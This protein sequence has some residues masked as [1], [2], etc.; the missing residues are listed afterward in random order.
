MQLGPYLNLL[1]LAEADNIFLVKQQLSPEFNIQEDGSW[2][3]WM[4]QLAVRI[5]AMILSDFTGLVNLLY[6]LDVSE[7]R[8]RAVL[9]DQ[10]G[11]DAGS[12]I[13]ALMVERQLEKIRT[14]ELY[15]SAK[16]IPDDEK[17]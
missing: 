7:P 3:E 6:R 5:N 4:N 8:I 2:E 14:R 15:R 10:A 13:A 12:L 11:S 17:W 1:N 9:S 16:D